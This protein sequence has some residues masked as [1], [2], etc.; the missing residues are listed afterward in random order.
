MKNNP[1]VSIIVPCYN[2]ANYLSVSLES[3]VKQTYTNW[4]CIIVNDGATDNTKQIAEEWCKKDVRFKYV[5]KENGGLSSA[6]NAG[7][8][9]VSGD[10]IQFL[11]ADDCMVLSKFEDSL[12]ELTKVNRDTIVVSNFNMFEDFYAQNQLNPYCELSQEILNFKSILNQWDIAFSIPI[13]CGFFPKTVFDTIRFNEV[14]RAKEDWL[15]WIQISQKNIP[16]VYLNKSLA[17]YRKHS[18]SM[19]MKSD[20]MFTDKISLFKELKKYMPQEEYNEFLIIRL[21]DSYKRIQNL[22]EKNSHLRNSKYYQVE[23]TIKK[24]LK[25]IKLYF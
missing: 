6:R 25:K 13:H 10:F 21:E 1:L 3:V 23:K 11:D 9:L 22:K 2:Q 15:F 16:F 24:I 19:T 8:N 4:E 20:K 18:Q 5:E 17:L 12:N 14:L 7:L